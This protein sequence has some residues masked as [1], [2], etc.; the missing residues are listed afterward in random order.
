MTIEKNDD[1]IKRSWLLSEI[2]HDLG[3]YDF[4]QASAQSMYIRLGDVVKMILAAPKEDLMPVVRCKD[5]LYRSQHPN[6]KGM[7]GCGGIETGHGSPLVL[8]EF[9]CAF[10]VK[11]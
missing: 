2:E 7:Y 11:R 1:C 4:E 3:C 8:P 5:C 9:F 6:N 10:G